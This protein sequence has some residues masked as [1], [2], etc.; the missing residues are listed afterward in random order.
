MWRVVFIAALVALPI[1][2]PSWMEVEGEEIKYVEM[3]GTPYEMGYQHGEQC[4]ELIAEALEWAKTDGGAAEICQ[5]QSMIGVQMDIT[6][7]R[8]WLMKENN[9]RATMLKNG[10]KE[11]APELLEEIQGIVDG[12]NQSYEDILI[13][14]AVGEA[15]G[16]SAWVAVGDAAKGH[17]YLGFHADWWLSALP[18]QVILHA[19]P[20]EGNRFTALTFA[21]CV[22]PLGGGINDKGLACTYTTVGT[23]DTGP[24]VNPAILCRLSLQYEESVEGVIE[25]IEDN[26]IYYG[27]NLVAVDRSGNGAVIERS[28]SNINVRWASDHDPRYVDGDDVLAVPSHYVS[29]QMNWW[30][31]SMREYPSSYYRYERLCQLLHQYRGEIDMHIMKLIDGDHYDLSVGES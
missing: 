25:V 15:M 1:F 5:M 20:L 17:A 19:N 23:E 29:E 13:L 3:E 8:Q 4:K 26:T 2:V 14:N 6:E 12:S 21:G 28:Y 11:T 9:H 27:C 24:G 30:S 22:G 7:I 18:Y 10:L 31:P 16:C